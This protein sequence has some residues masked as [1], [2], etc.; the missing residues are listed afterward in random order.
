MEPSE[1]TGRS[2]AAVAFASAF[3]DAAGS[4]DARLKDPLDIYEQESLLWI[5]DFAASIGA[6][7]Y[8]APWLVEML[9]TPDSLPAYGQPTAGDSPLVHR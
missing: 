8:A 6:D 1:L 7:P 3:M 4:G 2:V 5:Q 9:S